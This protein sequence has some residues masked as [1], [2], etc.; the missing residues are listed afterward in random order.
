MLSI[1]STANAVGFYIGSAVEK[2]GD[3]IAAA[4]PSI[5]YGSQ[6]VAT[7]SLATTIMSGLGQQFGVGSHRQ[8]KVN[9]LMGLCFTGIM[10]ASLGANETAAKAQA[11]GRCLKDPKRSLFTGC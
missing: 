4:M 9:L 10:M 11:L 1:D 5:F 3:G 6:W 7:V 8:T 2:V